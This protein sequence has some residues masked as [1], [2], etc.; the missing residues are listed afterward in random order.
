MKLLVLADDDG[1]RHELITQPVD[2][3][4]S[5][6]DVADF[7]ILEAAKQARCGTIL[8]V[9][10]ELPILALIPGLGNVAWREPSDLR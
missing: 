7:V 9:G 5:L 4:L 6:G 10:L 2:L 1:V 3:V 8:A